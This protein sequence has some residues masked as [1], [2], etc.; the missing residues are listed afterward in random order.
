MSSPFAFLAAATR[1]ADKAAKKHA[2]A[3]EALGA[4]Y[5]EEF[6]KAFDLECKSTLREIHLMKRMKDI[7]QDD[8]LE[9]I[10]KKPTPKRL[11]GVTGCYM[12]TIRPMDGKIDWPEFETTIHTLLSRKCFTKFTYSFE[13]K[14]ETIEDMGKGFHV[15]IVS[16]VTQDSKSQLLRDI[17]SS[18]KG[19]I[20]TNKIGESG[21]DVQQCRNPTETIQNYLIDYKS[22]DD[23]KEKTKLIDQQWRQVIGYDGIIVSDTNDW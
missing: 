8:F 12:I 21:I 14:G 11:T 22:D 19:W 20:A 16:K 7:I 4:N 10:E 5:K 1:R 9:L 3:M 2:M 13:Q 23:H 6:D 18:L 15:H 17:K